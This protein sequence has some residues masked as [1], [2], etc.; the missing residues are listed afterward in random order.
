MQYFMVH[1]RTQRPAHLM[2]G[3]HARETG[4]EDLRAHVPAHQQRQ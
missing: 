2:P 3:E 4:Q 1:S